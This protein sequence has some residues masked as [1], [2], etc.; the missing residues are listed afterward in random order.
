MEISKFLIAQ[1][2]SHSAMFIV[3]INENNVYRFGQCRQYRSIDRMNVKIQR[4]IKYPFKTS[5][6]NENRMCFNRCTVPD[7]YLLLF[8]LIRKGEK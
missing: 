6:V 3:V 1:N 7:G 4:E 2:V 8:E 5:I